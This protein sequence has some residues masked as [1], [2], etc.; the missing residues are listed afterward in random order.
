[1]AAQGLKAQGAPGD[2]SASAATLAI[3]CVDLLAVALGAIWVPPA[4]LAPA[5]YDVSLGWD[6][7]VS[8][9]LVVWLPP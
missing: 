4:L 2:W 7:H 3:P 8:I 1:M 5:R 9:A 6:A